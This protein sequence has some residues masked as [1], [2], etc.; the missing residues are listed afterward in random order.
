MLAGKLQSLY[1]VFSAAEIIRFCRANAQTA[2]SL[3]HWK[4][5][6]NEWVIDRLKTEGLLAAPKLAEREDWSTSKRSKYANRIVDEWEQ[7]GEIKA[8]YRDFKIN[9]DFA[10][11]GKPTRWSK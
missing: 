11:Q 10:R 3:I 2:H 9:L 1:C 5:A 4:H 7:A 8:L 6:L